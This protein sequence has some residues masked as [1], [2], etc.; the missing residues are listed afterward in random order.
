[1]TILFPFVCKAS[2]MTSCTE[3]ALITAVVAVTAFIAIAPC[4]FK[5]PTL[6]AFL[7][8]ASLIAVCWF[9]GNMSLALA[10]CLA[11]IALVLKMKQCGEN[12][13]HSVVETVPSSPEDLPYPE[14]N[15]E[16]DQLSPVPQVAQTA[17]ER[18]YATM[19]AESLQDFITAEHLHSA[20]NNKV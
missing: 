2:L 12:F 9:Y 5:R 11:Y 7:T 18:L 4:P 14:G 16:H 15:E 17:S 13:S 20:Q 8:F 10:V 1:M 19:T 3:Q 6:A